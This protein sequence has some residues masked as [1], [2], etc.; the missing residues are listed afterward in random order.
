[1]DN[2]VFVSDLS[3]DVTQCDLYELFSQ[4]GP[5]AKVDFLKNGARVTF[6]THLDALSAINKFQGSTTRVDYYR[7]EMKRTA[8][9]EMRKRKKVERAALART[10]DDYEREIAGLKAEIARLTK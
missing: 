7:R 5:V 3:S 6:T 10:P 4:V 8:A 2:S 1:M 9:R